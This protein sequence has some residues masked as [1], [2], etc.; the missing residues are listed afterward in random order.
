MS[1]LEKEVEE[2]E[3][4]QFETSSNIPLRVDDQ[5]RRPPMSS[6]KRL[7]RSRSIAFKS[8]FSLFY[9]SSV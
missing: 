7:E 5:R 9:P 1:K 4:L 8:E 3:L 6:C 2:R